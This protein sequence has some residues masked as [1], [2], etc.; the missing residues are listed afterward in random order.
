MDDITLLDSTIISEL[1]K[2]HDRLKIAEQS[3]SPAEK[4]AKHMCFV[5]HAR[6]L[7]K[8]CNY[9]QKEGLLVLEEFVYRGEKSVD[10]LFENELICQVVDGYDRDYIKRNF[11]FRYLS[12]KQDPYHALKSIMSLYVLI[13]VWEGRS[14]A[15]ALTVLRNIVPIDVSVDVNDINPRE[16]F[17]ELMSRELSVDECC[18]GDMRIMPGT[19]G[20]D[21][22]KLC[23]QAILSLD[24]RDT[25]RVLREISSFTIQIIMMGFSG[26]GRKHVFDNLSSRLSQ[27]VANYLD[28]NGVISTSRITEKFK[29]DNIKHFSQ[30]TV[31]VIRNLNEAGEIYCEIL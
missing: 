20:Y 13:C 8:Y 27:D 9:A 25:Q 17:D 5:K 14:T 30:M 11:L 1:Q 16:E 15:C 12:L 21:E 24:D 31:E 2:V 10:A 18:T 3:L 19:A 22:T 26:K 23:E 6:K 4:N 28:F 7:I 29:L